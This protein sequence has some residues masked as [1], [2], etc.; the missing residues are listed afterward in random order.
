ME[1]KYQY[2]EIQRKTFKFSDSILET[3]Y[4][5]F[6]GTPFNNRT[7]NP[8]RTRYPSSYLIEDMEYPIKAQIKLEV[9]AH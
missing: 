3:I 7:V 8:E 2:L 1:L 4:V 6:K 9:Y 5:K